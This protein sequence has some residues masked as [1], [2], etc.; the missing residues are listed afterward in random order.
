[1]SKTMKKLPKRMTT[2]GLSEIIRFLEKAGYRHGLNKVTMPW[3][4]NEYCT[5]LG[6]VYRKAY[7]EGLAKLNSVRQPRIDGQPVS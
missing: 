1:M 4:L 7:S 5:I 3:Q 2:S 6:Q